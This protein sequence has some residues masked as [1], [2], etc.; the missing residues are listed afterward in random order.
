MSFTRGLDIPD[1]E[2]VDKAILGPHSRREGGRRAGQNCCLF[3]TDA[4][5]K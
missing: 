4:K 2:K 3:K 5:Q 1:V